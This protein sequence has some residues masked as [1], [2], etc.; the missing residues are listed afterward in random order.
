METQAIS[1][2]KKNRISN[3]VAV[4]VVIFSAFLS[5]A[6]VKDDNIVQAMQQAK[7]NALD[8]WSEYQT[9]KLKMH[10]AEF[11][12]HQAELMRDGLANN[13]GAVFNKEIEVQNQSIERY[14]KD[15]EKLQEQA[16]A[17]ETNYDALN[18][19][20]DQFDMSDAL[21][22]LALAI[23]AVSCLVNRW[24][25]FFI[26]FSCGVGGI[27]FGVAGFLGWNFHPAW[28]AALLS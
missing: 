19:H 1:D 8:S 23:V 6:K 27:L 4:A 24:S 11:S 15:L 28:L 25:V 18:F 13:N 21:L 5:I 14:Q 17:Y 26:G 9:K 20:D 12:K 3:S 7:V 22:S 16:K 10:L 2:S